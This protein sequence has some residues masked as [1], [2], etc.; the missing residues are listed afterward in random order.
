MPESDKIFA[1]YESLL[2][3]VGENI[4]RVRMARGLTQRDLAQA[5]GKNQ[6]IVA[7][8]EKYPSRDITFRC[9]YEV[10]RALP[11]SMG[12]MVR[13]AEKELELH[14]LSREPSDISKRM[15]ALTGRLN[16]LPEEEQVWVADMIEGL[17]KR[18]RLPA[19]S[20]RRSDRKHLVL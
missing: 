11:V 18:T 1:Q 7:K 6:G 2:K 15:D 4:A 9:L 13:E 5:M 3:R 8:V 17:L 16:S 19:K 12:D 14:E 10:C 20:V